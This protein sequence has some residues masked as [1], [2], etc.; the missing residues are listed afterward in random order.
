MVIPPA[1]IDPPIPIDRVPQQNCSDWQYLRRMASR[2]GYEVYVDPGPAPGTNFLYFGPPVVPGLQQ[3]AISVNQGPSSDAYDIDVAHSG[4]NLTMVSGSVQDR[5]TGATLPVLA[6]TSTRSPLGLVPESL[7]RI[8]RTRSRPLETSGLN[9]MQAF[10]R[11]QGIVD[12]SAANVVRVTG[13]LDNTRYNAPL[14]ARGLVDLRGVGTTM[15]GTYKVAEVR[16]R[17]E[18]GSYTQ[19]FTLT[20]SELGPKLPLVRPV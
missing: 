2:H 15:N 1:V 9:A 13:T 18:R 10:A 14:K 8:G 17:I 4:E 19:D 7:R 6:P 11:A 20:R 16:H 3:K 12:D 5:Q